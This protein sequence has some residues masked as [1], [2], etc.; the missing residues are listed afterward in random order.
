[1][2]TIKE[3]TPKQAVVEEE[4]KKLVREKTRRATVPARSK[5][6]LFDPSEA[7]PP[8]WVE[9][10]PEFTEQY[11]W[12]YF[13]HPPITKP[14]RHSVGSFTPTG[15]VPNLMCC[16]AVSSCVLNLAEA[17]SFLKAHSF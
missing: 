1:M 17:Y 4:P 12:S 10:V 11:T 8:K 3:K 15:N 7:K 9:K 14:R 16:S 6:S 2:P 5:P 13:Q